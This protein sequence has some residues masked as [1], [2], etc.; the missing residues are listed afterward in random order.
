MLIG[1]VSVSSCSERD[2]R[3]SIKLVFVA[4][5]SALFC[6]LCSLIICDGHNEFSGVAGYV[7]AGRISA[8]YSLSF[9]FVLSFLN[10]CILLRLVSAICFL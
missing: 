5:L 6:I 2:V 7:S 8:L 10:L 3:R 4:N 1:S 9:V